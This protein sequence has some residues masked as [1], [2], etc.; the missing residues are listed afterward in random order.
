MTMLNVTFCFPLDSEDIYKYLLIY[1]YVH[2][3]R[4]CPSFTAREVEKL[5]AKCEEW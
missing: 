5:D 4:R 2:G 1:F 3:T